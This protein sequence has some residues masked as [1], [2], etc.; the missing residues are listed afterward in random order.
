MK[1]EKNTRLM[2][3]GAHPVKWIK[4]LRHDPKPI[5]YNIIQCREL[6]MKERI[7]KD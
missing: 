4:I 7:Q 1:M 2:E 5:S 6:Q 3:S